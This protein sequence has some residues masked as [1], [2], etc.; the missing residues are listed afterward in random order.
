[1][2]WKTAVSVILLVPALIVASAVTGL[3]DMPFPYGVWDCEHSACINP[4]KVNRENGKVYA[5]ALIHDRGANYRAMLVR[6]CTT[7]ATTA[8]G[9]PGVAEDWPLQGIGFD[10]LC[11]SGV[12]AP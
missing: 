7:G 5:D 4:Y 6:D 8:V 3:V 1:M 9:I 2:M 10:W 11:R 12:D